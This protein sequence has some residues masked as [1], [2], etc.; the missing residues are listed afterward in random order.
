M[1]ICTPAVIVEMLDRSVV[2]DLQPVDR[3]PC[4]QSA[5]GSRDRPPCNYHPERRS[6]VRPGAGGSDCVD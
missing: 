1:S 6:E 5:E 4:A 3:V 2:H